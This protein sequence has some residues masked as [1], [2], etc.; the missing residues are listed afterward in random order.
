MKRKTFIGF[1]NGTTGTIGI[2]KPDNTSVFRVIPSI[3]QQNYTKSKQNITRIDVSELFVFL[4]EHVEDMQQSLVVIER[5]MVNPTRFKNSLS[6]VRS[7]EAVLT[8]LEIMELPYMYIDSKEWQRDL[9]PKGL[10]TEDLKKA[11]LDIGIR[12]FPNHK[13]DI[14][15]HKDADGILIAEYIKRK[16]S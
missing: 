16:Y 10:K 14:L 4:G 7:L 9:L 13:D 2:I 1:D 5:P 11:S 8:V 15:N 3:K 12:L 6:A